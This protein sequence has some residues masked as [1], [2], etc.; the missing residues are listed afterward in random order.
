LILGSLASCSSLPGAAAQEEAYW[1]G[2]LAFAAEAEAPM[3]S[4]RMA[5]EPMMLSKSTAAIDNG[6]NQEVPTPRKQILNAFT[7]LRVESPGEVRRQ[8][9]SLT[10]QWGGYVE[11][12]YSLS[13]VLR[14]PAEIYSEALAQIQTLGDVLRLEESA[15]DV[16]DNYRDT[17]ARLET[18]EK[19]RDRLYTLLEKST[20]PEERARILREIGRLTEEIENIRQQL[21]L[22]DQ[23][24]AFSQI[25]V[26]LQ[27][28]LAPDL[29]S[30]EIPFPWIRDLNPLNPV[31]Q[32]LKARVTLD[33]GDS[34]A[35]FSKADTFY[36]EDTQG[37]L[38]RVSSIPNK[39]EGDSRFW[40]EALTYHLSP[41]YKESREVVVPWGDQ[42]LLGVN[43]LSKDREPYRYFVGVHVKGKWIHLVEFFSPLG[44]Q[45][46]S[47]LY[48][49][50]KEGGIR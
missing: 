49:V 48:G 12:S 36:A 42:E 13:L 14:V 19:T 2:D 27:P 24:V 26:E 20:D 37:R 18:A 10:R 43:F 22:L 29:A 50:L 41:F 17:S 15:W 30:V 21:T 4:A 46:W 33:L 40:Q 3:P 39:P 1:E 25:T 35:V 44:T 38:V 31:S 47:S 23:K 8:L 16:T 5:E 6:V 9:E 11:Q 7:R 45:D 34:W 32:K 28:R